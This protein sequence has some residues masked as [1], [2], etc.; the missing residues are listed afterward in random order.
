ML[1]RVATTA[2]AKAP[3]AA[4]DGLGWFLGFSCALALALVIARMRRGA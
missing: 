2:S 4:G 3:G 1:P